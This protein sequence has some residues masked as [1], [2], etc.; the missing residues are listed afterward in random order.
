MSCH[1]LAAVGLSQ[2]MVYV[3]RILLNAAPNLDRTNTR[4]QMQAVQSQDWGLTNVLA[5]LPPDQGIRI[6]GRRGSQ[7][8][9]TGIQMARL[10]LSSSQL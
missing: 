8:Q 9:M 6:A 4:T 7:K 3:S 1:L 5:M 10:R 2:V